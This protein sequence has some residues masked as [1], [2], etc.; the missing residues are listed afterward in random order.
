MSN[1]EKYVTHDE[2]NELMQGLLTGIGEM[3]DRQ[4]T[5]IMMRIE[6]GLGVQAKANGEAIA[7]LQKKVDAFDR[8]VDA[9][10]EHVGS[11][12]ESVQYVKDIV[13]A[14]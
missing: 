8:K 2:L 1:A 13:S 3:L 11:L 9:M 7:A 12:T 5:R 10:E 14:K 6:N 4:E